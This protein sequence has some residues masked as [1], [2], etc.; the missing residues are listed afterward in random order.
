MCVFKR[1]SPVAVAEHLLCNCDVGNLV[2]LSC[3]GMA[4]QPG[5]QF[6][7]DPELIGRCSEDILQCAWGDAFFAFGYEQRSFFATP[8]LQIVADNF[9][10]TVG[11]DHATLPSSFFPDP[12]Q[13][14][15][16]V[17]MLNIQGGQGSGSKTQGAQQHDDDEISQA[18]GCVCP[19][20]EVAE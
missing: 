10:N 17:D 3:R 16:E 4:E 5:V 19:V 2:K 14:A 6:F 15:C 20:G 11:Q 8:R 7:I 9:T 1:V 13:P 18:H 12:Q